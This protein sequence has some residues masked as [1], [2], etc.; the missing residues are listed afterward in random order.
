M[1][2]TRQLL[3]ICEKVKELKSQKNRKLALRLRAV[4]VEYHSEVLEEEHKQR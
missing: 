2:F 3:E 1:H 4:L